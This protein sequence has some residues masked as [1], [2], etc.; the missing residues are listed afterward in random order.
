MNAYRFS[1]GVMRSGYVCLSFLLLVTFLISP[2]AVFAQSAPPRPDGD[3][4]LPEQ[5]APT[6]P[7]AAAV[8]QA[9]ISCTALHEYV[10]GETLAQIAQRYN[11]TVEELRAAN[12]WLAS[13]ALGPEYQ[14]CI[15]AGRVIW[16]HSRAKLHA[17]LI[18]G[19]LTVWG[20]GFPK[21]HRY[22]VRVMA[23][24]SVVWYKIGH[25]DSAKNGSILKYFKLPKVIRYPRKLKVCL[26]ELDTGW[27]ICT[28]AEVARFGNYP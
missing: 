8:P 4:P 18:L 3:E 25:L 7:A 6:A 13:H 27:T 2:Q 20:E 1:R 15:P 23:D 26:K 22:N 17:Y 21:Y 19:H 11:I 24:R 5:A 14:L 10:A 9:G 12:P 28:K 16:E